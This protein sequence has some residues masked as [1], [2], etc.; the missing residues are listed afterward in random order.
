MFAMLLSLLLLLTIITAF[1]IGIMLGRWVI[2]CILHFFDP[3]RVHQ[4]RA[5]TTALA[6]S[7]G[8]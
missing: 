5:Q 8:N 7:P 3:A 1:A 2:F 6:P 4:K